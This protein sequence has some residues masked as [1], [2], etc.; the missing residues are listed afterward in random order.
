[1]GGGQGSKTSKSTKAGD[2]LLGLPPAREVQLHAQNR[3]A[4]VP[5]A[6]WEG[7]KREGRHPEWLLQT[8]T[9]PGHSCHLFG[10]MPK[11]VLNQSSLIGR[12]GAQTCVLLD[13]IAVAFL[14]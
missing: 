9:H 11:I 6:R 14:K 5:S 3:R 10:L 4:S 2:G 7:R 13:L 1:M 8:L 12:Q